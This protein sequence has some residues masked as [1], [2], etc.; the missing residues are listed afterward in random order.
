[1]LERIRK[2]WYIIDTKYRFGNFYVKYIKGYVIKGVN[3]SPW[4]RKM[5][6]GYFSI[7]SSK[8]S[9][10]GKL[11]HMTMWGTSW[12]RYQENIKFSKKVAAKIEAIIASKK[13][14]AIVW[15]MS[16]AN[17]DVFGSPDMKVRMEAAIKVMPHILALLKEGFCPLI[18]EEMLKVTLNDVAF[19]DTGSCAFEYKFYT[20]Y[21]DKD[22]R[23]KVWGVTDHV[24]LFVAKSVLADIAAGIDVDAPTDEEFQKSMCAYT[25]KQFVA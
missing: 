10:E 3:R 20:L 14:P 18:V 1:M 7:S 24:T 15:K 16:G 25:A 11:N 23:R 8:D 12:T 2:I 19:G 9:V 13:L 17:P 22:L 6:F 4:H 5:K 21:S